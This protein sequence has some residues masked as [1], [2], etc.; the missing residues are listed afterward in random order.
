MNSPTTAA[1]IARGSDT[2]RPANT[3]GNAVCQAI[4]RVTV[5]SLP[6]STRTAEASRGSTYRTPASVLKN[7]KKNTTAATNTTFEETPMPNQRISSGAS[8]SL[9]TPSAAVKNGSSAVR[10]W[11]RMLTEEVAPVALAA[12]NKPPPYGEL[13]TRLPIGVRRRISV[14]GNGDRWGVGLSS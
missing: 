6:P 7:R 4:S 12:G 13:G 8:A 5:H 9:G 11:F 10:R 14:H 3:Y 2:F 1:L